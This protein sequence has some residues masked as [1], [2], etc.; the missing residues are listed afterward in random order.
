MQPI[1][2]I[3]SVPEDDLPESCRNCKPAR[4]L[5]V[6]AYDRANVKQLADRHA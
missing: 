1:S 4:T 5:Q 2:V 6:T 3:F